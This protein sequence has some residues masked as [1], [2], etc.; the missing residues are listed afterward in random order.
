MEQE[1]DILQEGM[2]L[3][4]FLLR[5]AGSIWIVIVAAL[6]GAAI[7]A[8]GYTLYKHIHPAAKEYRT[9]TKYYIDFA[10]DSTGVGYGYYNDFTWNDWMKSDD[11]LPY[12]LSLLPESI[13]KETVETSVEADIISDVRL[14]TI[15][16]TTSDPEISNE[17]AQATAR[18]LIHFPEEIKEI[19]GIRVIRDEEAKEVVFGDLTK[20]WFFFGMALGILISVFI[21]WIVYCMDFS[22]YLP[23][24]IE[25]RFGLSVLGVF[26]QKR[27]SGQNEE[28]ESR[29]GRKEFDDNVSYILREKEKI[30]IVTIMETENA[31]ELI[32]TIKQADSM[33]RKE[34]VYA[35]SYGKTDYESM[36]NTDAGIICFTYGGKDSKLAERYLSDLEKQNCKIANAILLG[37]DEKMYHRYYW[38]V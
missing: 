18:S 22:V 8:G 32:Q 31:D 37:A 29:Y 21:R 2:D 12:T 4:F 9:E 15:T 38:G 35:G 36:R 19:D 25:K 14:L 23:K 5:L 7:C 28:R 3:R 33:S 16:V 17:I 20:N 30:S 13:S 27:K 26:Y 11:I 6:G 1:R 24:D 34:I 10:E